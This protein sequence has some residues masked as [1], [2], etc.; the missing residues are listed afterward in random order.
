M[1]IFFTVSQI[2]HLYGGTVPPTEEGQ[3]KNNEGGQVGVGHNTFVERDLAY[4]TSAC[5]FL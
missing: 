1:V 5:I 3:S 2:L 4:R